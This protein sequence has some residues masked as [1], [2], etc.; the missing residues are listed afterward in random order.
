M[1]GPIYM[2]VFT[3]L[4]MM[5]NSIFDNMYTKPPKNFYNKY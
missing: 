5:S 4:T 2:Y 3:I 1:V